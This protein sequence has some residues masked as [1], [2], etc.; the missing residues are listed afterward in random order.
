MAGT[1]HPQAKNGNVFLEFLGSERLLD[2][3]QRFLGSTEMMLGDTVLLV[4]TV[5]LL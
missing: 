1:F 3:A 5:V 2:T 4:Q